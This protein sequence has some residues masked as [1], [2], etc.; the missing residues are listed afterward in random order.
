MKTV[1]ALTDEDV[2]LFREGRQFRLQDKLGAHLADGG[3]AFAVWAPHAERV[4]VIGDFN[5]W[6]GEA[7]PLASRGRTGIWEGFVPDAA[8]GNRYKYRVTG[9]GGV[10]ENKADPMAVWAEVPPNSA[11]VIWDLAYEWGDSDWMSRQSDHNGLRAP[12]SIYEV[13]A[14]SW[15][16]VAEDGDRPLGYRE[17]AQRLAQHVKA[18]GFTHIELMPVM[19]HPFHGSWGYQLTGYFAATS[20]Y[21]TPQDLMALVEHLHQ[22]GIGVVL[23]WVPAHFPAD[24]HGLAQFDGTPIYEHPDPTR[25]FHPDWGSCIFDYG[26]PEVRSFLISSALFWLEKYHVDA[27]RV[28]GV[29]SMLYLD[30]SRKPG[31]W[32]PNVHG[33][34][35]N[36]EAVDFLRQLN[37]AVYQI[38]PHTQTIAE[39]STAWP[40][41]SRPVSVGGLGFGMKWDMGWMHDTLHY[42]ARDPV[43][44]RYHHNELTF[45]ALY[46]FTENF[47]LPLSHDEVVYGKGSL[48]HK[49]PGD[50][51]QQLAGV[52]LLLG[53]QYAL[54][55]KKLLF[56]GAELAQEGEWNHE[57][58]VEWDLAQLPEHAG[59]TRLL[60]DLNH[61]YR[62]E[63]ALH[64]NDFEAGGF[65]WVDAG[66]ADQSV[67]S[68]LR[69]EGR[70]TV[71]AV[72]NFTPVPRPGYRLGVP[73]RAAFWR[74]MVNSDAPEYGG[75]GQGNLG[76]V[77]AEPEP[78][79]GRPWSINLTVPPLGVVLLR[80][81]P[82]RLSG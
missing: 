81:E 72:C 13:H 65:Q 75:S 15:A 68:W 2:Y 79:H 12:W 67:L 35:E 62:E 45:R 19:E 52:R 78:W 56:M 50:R 76:G 10:I 23:D 70:R 64:R 57:G 74:E 7:H 9:P 46:A 20:R 33:G 82:S 8:R 1:P 31:E 11:S 16:R 39:E 4:S 5:Q 41:V 36:L 38:H 61:L 32:R 34:N 49:M 80:S 18:L 22:E 77:E 44:R 59:V 37:T 40:M 51:W 60:A 47:V 3:T 27:L 21:G 28:D 55:G 43:H 73:G 53:Y 69:W 24:A 30:Y 48:L 58:S 14:G 25:G 26:R 29:A 17:L 54:P 42:L 66:D 63:P 6:D 71:L